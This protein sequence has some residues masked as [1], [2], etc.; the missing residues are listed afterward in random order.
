M[1]YV[2]IA[3]TVPADKVIADKGLHILPPN[4]YVSKKGSLKSWIESRATANAISNANVTA[5]NLLVTFATLNLWISKQSGFQYHL[6]NL[7]EIATEDV[8]IFDSMQHGNEFRILLN[9][10]I[11]Y[12]AI[13]AF[14]KENNLGQNWISLT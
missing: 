4:E 12:R 3:T 10:N 14:Y 9:N 2:L 13:I 1:V 8:Y 6:Q 5:E 11:T 7:N